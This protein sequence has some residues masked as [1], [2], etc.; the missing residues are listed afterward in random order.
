[1]SNLDDYYAKYGRP[2]PK[3]NADYIRSMT[4]EELAKW[5]DYEYSR[6]EWCNIDKIGTDDC[7]DIDCTACILDWLKEEHKE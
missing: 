6:C 2:K 7:S 1:M 4:D 3:T 5:L